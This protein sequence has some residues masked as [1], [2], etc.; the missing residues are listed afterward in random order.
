MRLAPSSV[1]AHPRA[2]AAEPGSSS[3]GPANTEQVVAVAGSWGFVDQ[4]AC[5]IGGRVKARIFQGNHW[6]LQVDTAC[7]TL[8]VIRQN[9]GEAV[10]AEGE[11]VRLTWRSDDMALSSGSAA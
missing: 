7:G 5:S 8:T 4:A 9:S 3:V 1:R 2:T 10:P 11:A 6:L